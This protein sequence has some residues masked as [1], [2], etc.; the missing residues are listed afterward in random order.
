MKGI[1][2]SFSGGDV[3]EHP[4]I[5]ELRTMADIL[6]SAAWASINASSSSEMSKHKFTPPHKA[7]HRCF[8]IN[9]IIELLSYGYGFPDNVRAFRIVDTVDGSS[10][11]WTLGAFLYGQSSGAEDQ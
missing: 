3:Y 9:Y 6:C 1:Q 2:A 10:V 4:T 11:E 5:P 8:E 7:P